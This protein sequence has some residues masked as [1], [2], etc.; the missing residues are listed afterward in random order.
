[1]TLNNTAAIAPEHIIRT[2]NYRHPVFTPEGI[3]A[4]QRHR[5]INGTWRTWYCGAYWRNGFHEDGIVGALA[6]CEKFEATGDMLQPAADS[7]NPDQAHP[8][9][10]KASS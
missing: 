7:T 4:Q 8:S 3:A 6:V 10:A 5:E 9:T 2:F 1:M